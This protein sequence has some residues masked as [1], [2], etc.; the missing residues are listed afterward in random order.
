MGPTKTLYLDGRSTLV[1]ER[2]GPAL[3]VTAGDL[4][5]VWY[6]FA[7]LSYIL[8]RGPVGWRGD[9]LQACIQ[10]GLVVVFLDLDDR[11]TGIAS[12]MPA[13]HL[14]LGVRLELAAA[15]PGWE[16]RYRT[17]LQVQHQR[18]AAYACRA[19]GWPDDGRRRL[20]HLRQRLH[21]TLQVRFGAQADGCQRRLN[22]LLQADVA[23]ALTHA[24]LTPDQLAGLGPAGHLADDLQSL[25]QWPLRGKLLTLPAPGRADDLP[26]AA[27]LYHRFLQ[28]GL[29]ATCRRLVASLFSLGP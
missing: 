26:A 22:S 16:Q 14:G 18:R 29:T 28:P 19:L 7:R 11:C 15:R 9:A 25:L 17:W 8:C 23:A 10:Q 12:G 4:P 1:V 20:H 13:D 3:Q 24:G 27:A 21:Q 6:P 2:A 5:P